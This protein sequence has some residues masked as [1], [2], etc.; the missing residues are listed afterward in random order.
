MQ[1]ALDCF[2]PTWARCSQADAVDRDG[3]GGDRA[4]PRDLRAGDKRIGGR[5][6]RGHV[7]IPDTGDFAQSGGK[8]GVRHSEHLGHLLTQ[9]QWLQRAYPGA[10][11]A[12]KPAPDEIWDWLEAVPDPEIPVISVVDLGIVRD[13]AWEGDTL[14]VAVTPTYSGC[15]ATGDRDGDRGGAARSRGQRHPHQDPHRAALDHRLAEREGPRQAGGITASRRPQPAGGPERCPRCGGTDLS[16]SASSARPR[17]RRNGAA[18]TAW[19]PSTISNASEE[20][21]ERV[22]R[23]HD[24]TVTDIQ[25]TIRDA[26]VVTL[27]PGPK[28]RFR[29]SPWPVPDLP[30]RLRRQELRRTYSICAGSTMA[31][32]RSA[33][34]GSMAGRFPPS[35]TRSLPGDTL[36]AMPPMGSFTTDLDPEAATIT[37]GLPAARDHAGPVDPQ[38]VLAREPKSRFTL[39]YANRGVNTIMFREEIEDLKNL[40][41]GR[42]TVIHV[43]EQDAQEIDLFTGRV[44]EENAP[45][46]SALDRRGAMDMAFICGPEPMM[47]GIARALEAHGLDKDRIKFELF[48]SAA[49][50]GAPAATRRDAGPKWHRQGDPSFPSRWTARH[51]ASKWAQIRRCWRPHSP[52]ISTCRFPARPGV[53]STCRCKVTGG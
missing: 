33:S 9:M 8:T 30:A 19:N 7:D 4:R 10:V 49:A 17:A 35:P 18:A 43:L 28:G 3:R 53:C 6:G 16:G 42:L 44:T 40:H 25:K 24:L 14:V 20:A 21:R 50:T 27:R 39:V 22:P 29:L 23:F 45:S 5:P 13:V 15:P 51:G 32:C 37:W 52:M 36:Q 41:M 26:V 31:S 11:V 1:A 38:D 2:G 12:M 48:A 34:S 46:S 47:L